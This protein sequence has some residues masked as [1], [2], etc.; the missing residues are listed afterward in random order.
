MVRSKGTPFDSSERN[1]LPDMM[2]RLRIRR[3]RG[4]GNQSWRRYSDNPDSELA[5]AV[6]VA[7]DQ[8]GITGCDWVLLFSTAK[9]DEA[10]L[11]RSVRAAVGPTAKIANTAERFRVNVTRTV[12]AVV[13]KILQEHPELGRHLAASLRLQ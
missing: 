12:K 11:L 10:R 3:E 4:H 5:D 13:Q 9:P 7:L 2:E 1:A 8:S 6:G